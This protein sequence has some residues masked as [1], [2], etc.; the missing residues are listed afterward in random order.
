ML[1]YEWE[2][3]NMGHGESI[4][5]SCNNLDIHTCGASCDGEARAHESVSNE[6]CQLAMSKSV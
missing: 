1:A 2:V 4:S 6:G 3:P 5:M